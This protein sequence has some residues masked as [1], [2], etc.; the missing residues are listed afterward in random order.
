M[1]NKLTVTARL[2]N[3]ITLFC[4]LGCGGRVDGLTG[5]VSAPQYPL[6]DKK[7]L[8]CDWTVAVALGNKVRFAL[9]ALDDL[10]SSD[11]GGFCPLFAA[12]RIDVCF[13]NFDPF[14]K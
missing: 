10:N 7:N 1:T 5:I 14:E 11:S 8:K 9:T 2:T 3:R 13:K 6:G 4:I 12:N